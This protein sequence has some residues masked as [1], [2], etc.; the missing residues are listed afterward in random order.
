MVRASLKLCANR[1]VCEGPP[2]EFF[3]SECGVGNTLESSVCSF[4][5]V[6]FAQLRRSSPKVLA[7]V[8][9]NNCKIITENAVT[10]QM[11]SWQMLAELNPADALQRAWSSGSPDKAAA[12]LPEA[13]RE[14]SSCVLSTS[15][16]CLPPFQTK[17]ELALLRPHDPE[18]LESR[19]PPV[20][21]NLQLQHLRMQLIQL[22]V[23]DLDSWRRLRWH[24]RTATTALDSSQADKAKTWQG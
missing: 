7:P 5:I 6:W 16:N 24:S 8:N 10:A 12:E 18:H 19:S 20:Q 11:L 4:W 9:D 17:H 22:G 23:Q 2:C 14:S 21:L 3:K 13:R 15:V 1:T